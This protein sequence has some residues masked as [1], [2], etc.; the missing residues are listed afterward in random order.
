M[1]LQ[2]NWVSTNTHKQYLPFYSANLSDP[3]FDNLKGVYIIWY[4]EGSRAITVYA[5][6][7]KLGLGSVYI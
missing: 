3:Y 5:G 4:Q 2:L 7:V 1:A 6:Q